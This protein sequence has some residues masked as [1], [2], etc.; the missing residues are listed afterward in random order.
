MDLAEAA[1][2]M[3]V[4]LGATLGIMGVGLYLFRRSPLVERFGR[5]RRDLIQVLARCALSSRESLCLV[6]VGKEVVLLGLSGSQITLLLRLPDGLRTL[7]PRPQTLDHESSHSP[8]LGE[9]SPLPLDGE[10]SGWGG[11]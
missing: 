9:A 7:D 8:M 11:A 3:F 5:P 10:G 6:R 1:L 4:A 2:R